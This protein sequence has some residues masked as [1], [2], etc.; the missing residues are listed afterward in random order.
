MITININDFFMKTLTS[1]GLAVRISRG[2]SNTHEG[3]DYSGMGKEGHQVFTPIEGIV[4]WAHYGNPGTGNG[5]GN[6]IG[7]EDT[8]GNIH[9][10]AHL[11]IM[12][13]NPN[14]KVEVNDLIGTLGNTGFSTGPHLHYHIQ[15]GGHLAG[16]ASAL[17]TGDPLGYDYNSII[18]FKNRSDISMPNK[19]YLDPG[20]GG[21]DPGAV[22]N[23]LRES[24]VNLELGLA[25]RDKLLNDY[26]CEVNMSRETDVSP[27]NRIH[28]AN[29]WD[30]DLFFSLHSNSF[31][32]STASGYEDFIFTRVP[33][34]TTV[35]QREIHTCVASVWTKYGSPNRGMKQANF[36]VLRE[37]RMCAVLVENGFISNPGDADLLK[38]TE[39]K[40]E[41]VDGMAL[42]IANAMSL[43]EKLKSS[44]NNIAKDNKVKSLSSEK[45]NDNNNNVWYRVIAG[46]FK[47]RDNAERQREILKTKGYNAFISV[48]KP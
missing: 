34:A 8:A 22:G 31:R 19:I 44:S 37:T 48:Y 18:S 27:I 17:G 20:H 36:E 16:G 2:W 4:R 28:D 39:F 12:L 41:L 23:G 26:E 43:K 13:V 11:N 15:R 42:G 38:N 14:D 33:S 9:V 7:I 25:L 5:F 6:H 47:E 46:S 32:E 24:D 3:I 35:A 21:H 29:R 30:A 40:K 1:E 10:F 45:T